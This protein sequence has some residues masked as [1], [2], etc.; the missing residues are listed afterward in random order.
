[1]PLQE[2]LKQSKSGLALPVVGSLG[3][4]VLK[5]LL[6]PSEHLGH[7]KA[8]AT[9]NSSEITN[10]LIIL[11]FV[12]LHFSLMECLTVETSYSEIINSSPPCC[13]QIGPEI[14]GSRGHLFMWTSGWGKTGLIGGI[15]WASLSVTHHTQPTRDHCS[16][17]LQD[18]SKLPPLLSTLC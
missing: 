10:F 5:V 18:A 9:H 17:C 15:Y 11:L 13:L 4:S 7:L 8:P 16:L 2:V 6:E 12:S 3:P 1:M 14:Q